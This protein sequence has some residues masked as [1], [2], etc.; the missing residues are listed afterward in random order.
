MVTVKNLVRVKYN[1]DK[2]V[3]D[4]DYG[5]RLRLSKSK[6]NHDKHVPDSD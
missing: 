2:H 4:K 6:Y 5:L 3:Q 1:H